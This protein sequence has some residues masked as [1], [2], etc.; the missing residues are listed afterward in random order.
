L[1]EFL[2][3]FFLSISSFSFRVVQTTVVQSAVSVPTE[4]NA[5]TTT[6]TPTTTIAP[7]SS[8]PT[9]SIDSSSSPKPRTTTE[10]KQQKKPKYY[11][12]WNADD[13]DGND[14]DDDDDLDDLDDEDLDGGD[15]DADYDADDGSLVEYEQDDSEAINKGSK[16]TSTTV[17]KALKTSNAKAVT[18][19]APKTVQLA[20]LNAK[21]DLGLSACWLVLCSFLPR[22][23][24]SLILFFFSVP[25]NTR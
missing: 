24:S 12:Q 15:Q 13:Y 11:T 4:P 18:E 5:L 20:R 9:S 8:K 19:T 10:K 22:F 3:S 25:Q 21:I 16:L 7:T 23:L 2:S 6:T 14:D 17:M 1:I